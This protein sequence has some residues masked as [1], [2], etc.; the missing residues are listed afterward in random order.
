MGSERALGAKVFGGI[1]NLTL[2]RARS[3]WGKTLSENIE[4]NRETDRSTERTEGGV[5]TETDRVR[6]KEAS[7]SKF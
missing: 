3:R 7:E 5:E 4:D 2:L 1:V 6:M